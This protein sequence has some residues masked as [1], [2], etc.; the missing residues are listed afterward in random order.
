LGESVGITI[1]AVLQMGVGL[2]SE[3]TSLDYKWQFLEDVFLSNS[4]RDAFSTRRGRKVYASK[5]E[6]SHQIVE[7]VLYGALRGLA[8]RYAKLVDGETHIQHIATL[9]NIVSEKCHASLN[10]RRLV[11]GVAQKALNSYLKYLWCA[12]RMDKPPHCPFDANIISAL[13]LPPGCGTQWTEG[14]EADYR[15]WVEAA[16]TKAE[17]NNESL[18]DWELRVWN[19]SA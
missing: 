12:G 4:R 9:A 18:A 2:L 6:K 10:E 13:E 17:L 7:A 5:D 16:K 15:A 19:L 8:S 14:T 11:F 3:N 1:L